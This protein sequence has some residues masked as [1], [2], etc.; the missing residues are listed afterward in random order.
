MKALIL[1][2]FGIFFI[3]Q[4]PC[5]AAKNIT[6]NN[7]ILEINKTIEEVASNKNVTNGISN[8]NNNSPPAGET[9]NNGDSSSKCVLLQF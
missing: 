2:G 4:T 3:I 1:F 8:N 9:D 5:H 7:S 6:S